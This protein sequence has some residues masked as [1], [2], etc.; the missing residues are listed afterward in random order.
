M[1]GVRE[2]DQSKMAPGLAL[3]HVVE[4]GNASKVLVDRESVLDAGEHP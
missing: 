3:E 2:C 4:G 1:P